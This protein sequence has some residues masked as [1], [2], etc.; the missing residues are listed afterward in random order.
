M[1]SLVTPIESPRT[2][3]CFFVL[4]AAWVLAA[5]PGCGRGNGPL[6]AAVEG[7]VDLDGQ[8]LKSGVV[9]F[10]PLADTQ[11]PAASA[12]VT[13]GDF[14]LSESDGPV[15]GSHRVEIDAIDYFGF[16]IDDEAAFVRHI[17]AAPRYARPKSPVPDAYHR[18]SNL[19]ARIEAGQPN[20]LRFQLRSSGAEPGN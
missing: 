20:R 16:A 19:T 10:I 3:R 2:I 5:A 8:P 4:G 1:S 17:E 18:R 13:D 14:A 11:G 6:R 12:T 15:V 9:R 7:R